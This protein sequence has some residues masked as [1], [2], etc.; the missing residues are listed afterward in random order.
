[1]NIFAAPRQDLSSSC[2]RSHKRLE[3]KIC[4]VRRVVN[5]PSLTPRVDIAVSSSVPKLRY[6]NSFHQ[7]GLVPSRT[8]K[9]NI[10]AL[11]P[12][13]A[14]VVTRGWRGNGGLL[15]E[16]KQWIATQP[17]LMNSGPRVQDPTNYTLGPLQSFARVRQRWRQSKLDSQ[18]SSKAFPEQVG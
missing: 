1:M 10:H 5:L 2:G 11:K 7:R 13:C 14:V 12:V 4:E 15:V 18:I 8:S 17:N 9:Q 6:Q 3:H 16:A